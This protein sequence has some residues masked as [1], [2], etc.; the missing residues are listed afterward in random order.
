MS[1]LPNHIL[2]YRL[3]WRL[4]LGSIKDDPTSKKFHFLFKHTEEHRFEGV[5][6][7]VV[8][9]HTPLQWGGGRLETRAGSGTSQAPTTGY[10]SHFTRSETSKYLNLD[11]VD[12]KTTRDVCYF[13][14]TRLELVYP[15]KSVLLGVFEEKIKIF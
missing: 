8:S 11:S 1:M 12:H 15:L 4:W 7:W 14:K 13:P 5:D 10:Q 9:Q 3:V 6:V 2:F